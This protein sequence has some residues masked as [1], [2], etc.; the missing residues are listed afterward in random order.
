METK[1]TELVDLANDYAE[2]EMTELSELI[3]SITSAIDQYDGGFG[4]MDHKPQDLGNASRWLLNI[5]INDLNYILEEETGD[6]A[7]TRI[8]WLNK[9]RQILS[10]L[11]VYYKPPAELRV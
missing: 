3:F 4:D 1:F 10:N 2:L 9:N 6:D 11:T 8:D 7:I 5:I